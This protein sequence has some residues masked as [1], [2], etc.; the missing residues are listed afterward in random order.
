MD[1]VSRD[2]SSN[3]FGHSDGAPERPNPDSRALTRIALDTLLAM[4]GSADDLLC[5]TMVPDGNGIRKLGVSPRYTAIA[6]IGML[7]A[8]TN[9]HGLDIDPSRMVSVLLE[10]VANGANIGDVG[11][12]SWVAALSGDREVCDNRLRLLVQKRLQETK[13]GCTSMEVQWLL[14]GLCKLYRQFPES[15]WLEPLIRRCYQNLAPFYYDKTDLFCD[16]YPCKLVNRWKKDLSY[17]CNQTYGIYSLCTYYETFGDRQVLEW[18]LGTARKICSLQGDLGQWPWLFDSRKGTVVSV[19]PVYSVHQD[20]MAPMA[21]LKLSDLSGEDFTPAV[22]RGISW[23]WGKNELGEPLVDPRR[24]V[25]WRSIRKRT[26][27]QHAHAFKLIKLIHVMHLDSIRRFAD[28]FQSYE[29]DRECRPYEL[30]WL[31]C[32][33]SGRSEDGNPSRT[34]G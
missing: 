18:A 30:G 25:I 11:L 6:L 15:D 16:I 24:G 14:T 31:L 8:K 32:A 13:C 4:M 12:V 23:V 5:F 2:L 3:A 9:G 21:L 17:F 20:A 26:P 27:F 22:S 19:Y 34:S 28:P 29:I 33:F 7:T 10:T 1:H